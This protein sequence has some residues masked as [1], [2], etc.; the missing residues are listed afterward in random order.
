[1]ESVANEELHNLYSSP[2]ITW[3]KRWM[4]DVKL[5][6]EIRNG[7]KILIGKPERKRL[8]GRLGRRWGIKLKLTLKKDGLRVSVRSDNVHFFT[9]CPIFKTVL[10]PFLYLVVCLG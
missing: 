7:Y 1:M 2:D 9:Q 5:M 6:V 10:G 8:L 4:G 3:V